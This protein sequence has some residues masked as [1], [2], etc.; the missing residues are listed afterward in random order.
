MNRSESLTEFNDW[1]T[2]NYQIL[3]EYAGRY[4]SDNYD[5][6]NHVYI[7]IQKADL[8]KVMDNPDAYFRK[9]IVREA[10]RGTFKDIYTT[11]NDLLFEPQ[12]PESYDMITHLNR[13]QLEIFTHMLCWFDKELFKLWLKGENISNLS[14]DS[15]IALETL[16]TSLYRTKKKIK[17]A[18]NFIKDKRTTPND[19]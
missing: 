7:R 17:D 2:K 8:T 3:V 5:L 10:T 11:Y 14:R 19:L 9:V 1:V 16:H 4:H 6:V 15:G 13:E 18:F 12:A